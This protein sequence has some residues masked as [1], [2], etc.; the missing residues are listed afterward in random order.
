MTDKHILLIFLDGI[1]L[2]SDDAALNPFALAQLPTLHQLTGGQRWLRGLEPLQTD[3][4]S[5]TPTD[6]R[7]G[8][9][10]R[11]QSASGQA[12]ILTGKNIPALIGEHYG[13]RPNEAIRQFLAEDNFFLRMVQMGKTAAL[14]EA[15][16]PRWHDAV[17]S[18][19]RLRSSYQHAA[20]VAGLPLFDETHI[21]NREAL[22]VDWTG[23]GW[24]SELGYTD[25]PVY[26]PEEAGRLMVTI[27]R[28]YDFAFF[29]HWLTD[30][31]GHR[32]TLGEGVQ[33]LE[34]FDRVM[35]G[36]LAEWQDDEG[37]MIITSDHG[38]LEDL[39]HGKHTD[40]DVPTI[41]IGR[42]SAEFVAGIHT[43][44]DLVPQMTA[45]YSSN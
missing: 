22:A 19:K 35:A 26:S 44:A 16:P 37:L 21:Y 15:Y 23:Q 7:M 10:G 17:N 1:G 3:R 39:S 43:L 18:G 20:H 33:I 30:M 34:L 8:V 31:I 25:T 40:N 6:P 38:N 32:G 41:V 11:P 27:S 5:F 13:P 2:G 28:R 12:A 4:A 9:A 36:A 24:R 45:F 42:G 29:S 14:L